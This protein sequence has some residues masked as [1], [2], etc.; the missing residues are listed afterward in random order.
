VNYAKYFNS[1]EESGSDDDEEDEEVMPGMSR[2][3]K[4]AALRE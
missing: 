2:R 1:D 3:D 4:R